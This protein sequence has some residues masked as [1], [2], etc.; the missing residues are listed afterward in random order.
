V[1]L[2]I[3]DLPTAGSEWTKLREDVGLTL[4]DLAAETELDMGTLRTLES[5]GRVA[6]STRKLVAAACGLDVFRTRSRVE[7]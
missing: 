7:T 5:G 3:R 6:R 1:T 4:R 2:L